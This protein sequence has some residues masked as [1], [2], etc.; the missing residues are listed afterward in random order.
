MASARHL[1][2]KSALV[3]KRHKLF[4]SVRKMATG[5][6]LRASRQNVLSDERS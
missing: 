2:A 3:E 5:G 1:D 6:Q 4:L